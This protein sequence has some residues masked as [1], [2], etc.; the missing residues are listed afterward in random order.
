VG[1][2]GDDSAV[3]Q[4]IRFDGKTGQYKVRGGDDV[5]NG[6]KYVV[7]LPGARAG[8]LRFTDGR[9]E[10]HTGPI[11]PRDETP[12]RDSLGDNDPSKWT[13]GRFSNGKVEDPYKQIVEI[14]L[15]DVETG[16]VA[17]L[18]LQNKG[19]LAASSAF[20]KK[21]LGMPDDTQPVVS[22]DTVTVPSKFGPLKRPALSVTGST[23]GAFD[24]PVDF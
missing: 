21:C 14:P 11:F 8:Y 24:D 1:F 17:V 16:E 15:K 5:C 18:T 2:F 23:E 6:R 13:P 3:G 20:F 4:Y 22:L 9:P 19:G 12:S 10:R 7:D